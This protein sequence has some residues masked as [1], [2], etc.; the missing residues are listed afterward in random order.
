[1]ATSNRN[2]KRVFNNFSLNNRFKVICHSNSNRFSRCRINNSLVM[3][4]GSIKLKW[5]VVQVMGSIKVN[6]MV[7]GSIMEILVVCRYSSNS[8]SSHNKRIMVS[9]TPIL[10]HNTNFKDQIEMLSY[11][12]KI[13]NNN[14]PLETTSTTNHK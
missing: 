3:V 11:L 4:V 1:M 9:S 7:V 8:I 10:E 6:L 12:K 2:N 13:Q 14:Q 5:M